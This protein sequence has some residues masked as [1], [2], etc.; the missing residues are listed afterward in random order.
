[1]LNSKLLKP[2]YKTSNSYYYMN[3]TFK[4]MKKEQEY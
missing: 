2:Q 1:M 3:K 4:L